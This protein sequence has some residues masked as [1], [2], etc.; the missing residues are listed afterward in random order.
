M[1]VI[2]RSSDRF[3]PAYRFYRWAWAGLDLLYPPY[4]GGCGQPGARWCAACQSSARLLSPPYCSFCGRPG[5]GE[6]ACLTCQA[7]QPAYTALRSWAYFEGSVRKALHR[8]KYN[9]EIGLGEALAQPLIQIIGQTCWPL[10]LVTPVP[11]GVV[12]LTQRGYN[13]ASLLAW[14]IALSSRLDYAPRA[15]T[16]IRETR[17]QVGL[18]IAQ[19]FENVAG[20]FQADGA[21]VR[22][23]KVLVVDDVTT[24]GAT[25]QSCAAALLAAGACQ[26]YGLTLTRAAHPPKEAVNGDVSGESG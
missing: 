6:G 11:L 1:P 4:C 2:E 25:L 24:S 16:K 21:V 8:L 12:R 5:L 22:G 18:N 10:D 3:R 15:L 26:V 9:G 20:A 23:K 17:S 14:P 13:Q 19:R 7:A